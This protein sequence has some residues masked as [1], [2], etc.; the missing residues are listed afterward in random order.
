MITIA[1]TLQF[2]ASVF[3]LFYYR[4]V[5]RRHGIVVRFLKSCDLT[6]PRDYRTFDYLFLFNRLYRKQFSLEQVQ[7]LSTLGN[8]IYWFNETARRLNDEFR[9]SCHMCTGTSSASCCVT[10]QN[11]RSCGIAVESSGITTI[12]CFDVTDADPH[13]TETTLNPDYTHKLGVYWNLAFTDY[14]GPFRSPCER[15]SPDT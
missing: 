9:R 12:A 4:G 13:Y 7:R 2:K 8:K 15:L 1:S 11:T 3:P 6:N 5:L 14:R 10:P